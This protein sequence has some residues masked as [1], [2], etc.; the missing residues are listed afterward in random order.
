MT[1]LDPL[2]VD[3]LRSSPG[4]SKSV[5][6]IGPRSLAIRP[7]KD[8]FTQ[9]DVS[10]A[11]ERIS[12]IEL[13]SSPERTDRRVTED[14]SGYLAE[15]R[16]SRPLSPRQYSRLIRAVER[17][18]PMQLLPIPSR[19]PTDKRIFTAN[20]A[21]D[22]ILESLLGL[23]PPIAM[24]NGALDHLA[25]SILE[26]NSR[27]VLAICGFQPK[28]HGSFIDHVLGE[29]ASVG[30]RPPGDPYTRVREPR[31]PRPPLDEDAIRRPIPEQG[32][33]R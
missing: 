15:V 17:A 21:F 9:A 27:L 8:S 28:V 23:V 2:L 22:R 1:V 11:I 19:H 18:W 5:I 14:L 12:S 10:I 4:W 33:S 32:P 30:L 31:N 20:K 26:G 6:S 16:T 25:D 24:K 7:G 29:L 13:P 3:L